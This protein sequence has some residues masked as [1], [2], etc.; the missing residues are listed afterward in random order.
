MPF[1]RG[2]RLPQIRQQ[3]FG[4]LAQLL[5]ALGFES[6][7]KGEG[8]D[9]AAAK[10]SDCPSGKQGGS[11][12]SFGRGQMVPE[13]DKTAFEL[14]VGELSPVIETQFGYHI[15]LV[16]KKKEAGTR[17][18]EDVVTPILLSLQV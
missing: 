2:K 10:H 15:I 8:F 9:E 1:D 13:F 12:G 7:A 4:F 17:P 14:P 16:D 3:L 11:L 6:R 18:F 5:A